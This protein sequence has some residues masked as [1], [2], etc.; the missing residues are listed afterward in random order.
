MEGKAML[1]KI[2]VLVIASVLVS[3]ILIEGQVFAAGNKK[4]VVFFDGTSSQ[5]QQA[6]VTTVGLIVGGL[7]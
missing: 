3:V 7:Q 1:R 4:I 5:V 2:W 6:A